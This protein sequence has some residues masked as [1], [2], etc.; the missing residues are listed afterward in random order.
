MIAKVLSQTPEASSEVASDVPPALS[1][2]VMQLMAKD[3]DERVQTA[4]ALAVQLDGI[5]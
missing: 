1:S 2:L 4:T 5:G 3:K